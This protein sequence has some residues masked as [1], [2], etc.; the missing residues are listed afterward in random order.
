ASSQ[1]VGGRPLTATG[2]ERAGDFA[3]D[4]AEIP[5]G[6]RPDSAGGEAAAK[7]GL[8]EGA[9]PRGRVARG[10]AAGGGGRAAG[11]GGA[12]PRDLAYGGTPRRRDRGE[13]GR[14]RVAAPAARGLCPLTYRPGDLAEVDFFEVLVDVAGER[15]K[16]WLFLL[17][18]MSSARDFGW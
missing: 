7:T 15:R 3:A 14:C 2:R 1:G 16:A 5:H 12:V 17:R 18:L 13:R 10:V 9:R 8:G 6:S 4:R 11:G